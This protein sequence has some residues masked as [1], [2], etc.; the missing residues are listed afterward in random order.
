MCSYTYC[1]W[2]AE[3]YHYS[4]ELLH[5]LHTQLFGDAMQLQI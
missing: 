2:T 5:L 3:C 1:N 4:C